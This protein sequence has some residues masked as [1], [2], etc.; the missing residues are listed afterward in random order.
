MKRS[1][2]AHQSGSADSDDGD[3]HRRPYRI[4]YPD[5]R[6]SFTRLHARASGDGALVAA[7]KVSAIRACRDGGT[8]YRAP[9]DRGRS[10]VRAE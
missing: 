1:R 4:V 8:T 5:A 3:A 9:R 10:A 2:A 6:V 7:W